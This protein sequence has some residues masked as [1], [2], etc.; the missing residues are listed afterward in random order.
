MRPERS[1]KCHCLQFAQSTL[2]ISCINLWLDSEFMLLYHKHSYYNHCLYQF[3]KSSFSD[4]C[5]IFNLMITF[6]SAKLRRLSA[7]RS[8]SIS[9][10]DF[11]AVV[12]DTVFY[13]S[14]MRRCRRRSDNNSSVCCA[15]EL[16]SLLSGIEWPRTKVGFRLLITHQVA[17]TFIL[18]KHLNVKKF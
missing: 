7:G 17:F 6:N 11:A 14:N 5:R 12:Y 10:P 15:R 9:R 13:F 4:G 18:P 2:L 8:S 16:C 1:K 3:L